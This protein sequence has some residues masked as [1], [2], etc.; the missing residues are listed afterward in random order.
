VRVTARLVRVDDETTVWSEPYDRPASEM[1][2]VQSE[3]AEKV[4][5][6]LDLTLTSAEREALDAGGTRDA[7]AYRA[8]L[9]GVDRMATADRVAPE[10]A[11][12]IVD[13]FAEAVRIDPAFALAHTR[14][15]AAH[16]G[17][18]NLGFDVTPERVSLTR[19]RQSM[20][21]A[22]EISPDTAWLHVSRGRYAYALRDYEQAIEE[23]TLAQRQ[24]PGASEPARLLASVLR[25]QGRIERALEEFR[26]SQQLNPR[27]SDLLREI[28]LTLTIL[29]RY[30]EALTEYDRAL[31][32]SSDQ[33]GLYLEK[34]TALVLGRGDVDA[35]RRVQEQTP[36]PTDPYV[37][38]RAY[39]LDLLSRDYRRA[40]DRVLQSPR[41]FV[42][43]SDLHPQ[44]LLLGDVYRSLGE[45]ALAARS[46]ERARA[47]LERE[48]DQ[49]PEEHRVHSA[50][51]RVYAGLGRKAEAVAAASRGLELCP[52]SKDALIGPTRIEDLARVHVVNGEY[53]A[54]LKYI[55]DLLA[56]PSFTFSVKMLEL[57]PVWDPLRT[58]P[59]YRALIAAG[60]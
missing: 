15:S 2:A 49:R 58:H 5:T 44:D 54:A 20:D 31:A 32:L 57:H 50:L 9:R 40:L 36:T 39:R 14:L 52:P 10:G 35:A 56:L 21:R 60:R 4:A 7:A 48:R 22:R 43:Q 13:A 45:D 47:F 33:V 17:V 11:R 41:G 6:A 25:R 26:R 23:L 24:M 34:S 59:R 19:A 53:D 28:G 3:I 12:E 30:D 42:D 46:Y 37:V 27:S 18:Y 16:S 8:Y 29:R 38:R 55:E 1:F 51:G